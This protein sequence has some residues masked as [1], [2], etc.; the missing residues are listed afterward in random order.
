[1]KPKSEMS[2]QT[3]LWLPSHS[4]EVLTVVCKTSPMPLHCTSLSSVMPPHH[5]FPATL[6]PFLVVLRITHPCQET[7]QLCV[8]LQ[9]VSAWFAPLR[10]SRF[11]SNVLFS[12]IATLLYPTFLIYTFLHSMDC[13]LSSIFS[14]FVSICVFFP[15]ECKLCENARFCGFALIYFCYCHIPVHNAW[16]V[17]SA[18]SIF[19]EWMNGPLTVFNKFVLWIR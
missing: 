4:R 7:L 5:S 18:P 15:L 17:E 9:Q 3:L 14:L 2:L 19:V 1:M 10:P 16:H 11:H 8:F 12:V 6:V 13:C